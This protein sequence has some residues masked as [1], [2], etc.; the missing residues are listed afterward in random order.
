MGLG[1]ADFQY[2]TWR[3]Q[4]GIFDGIAAYAGRD[5]TI[6]GSGEPEQLKA[7][8]VTPGFLRVM[9]T[10]PMV[11][12]DFIPRDAAPRGGQVALLSYPFWMRRFGGD[13]SI[14]SR[15]LTL[16]GKPYSVAGVLPRDFEF[17]E[18]TDVN[19]MVALSEPAEQPTGAIYFY[20]VIARMRQ[21]VTAERAEADLA[22]INKRL[23]SAYSQRLGRTQA[24]AQTRLIGL[25]DNLVGNVRPALLVLAGAVGLV[26][27]IVCVNICN[28]LLARAIARQKE[29]AV[30]IALGA[31]RARVLR[32]L[33]TEGMLLAAG[34][35]LAGLAFAC[36]GVRLLRAMAPAGVP[37]IDEAQI[38]AVVLGFNLSIALCAGL[39]FGLAPAHMASGID[40]EAALKKT[41][42]SASGSRR[43]RRLENLLIASEVAFALVLL[44]GAGLLMRTFAGLTAIA[45][46]F[47]PENILTARLSLPYW[48][49]RTTERQRAFL[50]ALMQRVRSGPGD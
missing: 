15:Q 5:F 29:I 6:T 50:D 28:L 41:V 44:A 23:E 31:G 34:G 7:Q 2:A 25:H 3:D 35:G 11:G 1:V 21:D 26:L 8:T 39:V 20:S 42:R 43:Q 45:P 19:L 36:G 14:L 48:K 47:H 49:Y 17:P 38:S 24:G 27:L 16:D 40:P 22:L 33:V 30:R 10:T 12:R 9:E 32:Q 37:H 13:R 4:T 46:G 18:N